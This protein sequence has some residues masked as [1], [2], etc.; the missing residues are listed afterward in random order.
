M[1]P[2]CLQVVFVM[3][4]DA[5]KGDFY[6]HVYNAH[7][8]RFSNEKQMLCAWLAFMR[9]QD[10]DA[11]ALFEVCRSISHE[12]CFCLNSNAHIEPPAEQ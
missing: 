6:D 12:Q 8:R 3:A 10:V 4:K 2:S 9:L 5:A 7:V 1:L 11:I